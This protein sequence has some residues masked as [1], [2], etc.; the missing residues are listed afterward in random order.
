MLS[1]FLFQDAKIYLKMSKRFF[2]FLA[3]FILLFE[4]TMDSA[5]ARAGGRSSFGGGRSSTSYYNQGSRGSRTFE[6]GGANGKNYAPMQR[7]AAPNSN[8][9]ANPETQNPQNTN[10]NNPNNNGRASSFFS[11]HPILSTVGAALAG[12]WLGHMIFGAGGFGAGA[13]G[14]GFLMNILLMIAGAFVVMSLVKFLT[15]RSQNCAA[16]TSQNSYP[17]NGFGGNFNSQNSEFN[18][19]QTTNIILPETEKNK[20]AQILIAVQAAWSAQNIEELKKVATPEMAKYFS[21]AL[22]QNISQGIANK[23]ENIEVIDVNVAEAWR[24]GEMEYATAIIE[25][26]AFDYMVNVNQNLQIVEGNDKNLT[27]ISEAW[28][29]ARYNSSGSWILSAIAQVQ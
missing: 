5:M 11:R 8:K 1:A 15:R 17:G 7:S 21:D 4:A 2:T 27:M 12:S 23:I 26:S 16:A 20:F 29:F 22:A 6:G 9:N 3:T 13:A 24:E 28:T 25:W 10:A 14:G 18:Q 19:V